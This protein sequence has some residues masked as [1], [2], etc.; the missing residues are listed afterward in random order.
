MSPRTFPARRPA[1]RSC[2]PICIGS[3]QAW[4]IY[5]VSDLSGSLTMNTLRIRT[6]LERSSDIA[7]LIIMKPRKAD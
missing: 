7:F 5:G 3:L 1:L 2:L 4:S 6:G